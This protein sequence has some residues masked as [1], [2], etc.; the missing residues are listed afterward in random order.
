MRCTACTKLEVLLLGPLKACGRCKN[1]RHC[2]FECQKT[3]WKSHKVV[4]AAQATS[5]QPSGPSSSADVSASI[6]I[7]DSSSSLIDAY[8]LRVADE[9]EYKYK[10][11][12][13]ILEIVGNILVSQAINLN[14]AETDGVPVPGTGLDGFLDL[15]EKTGTV[16]PVWWS[17]ELR[18]ECFA[19]ATGADA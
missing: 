7:S 16:M 5:Q 11:T 13:L 18:E 4:C 12:D 10:H 2:S 3:D 14:N 17:K 6:S 9:I 15:A 19:L 8:R 1:A